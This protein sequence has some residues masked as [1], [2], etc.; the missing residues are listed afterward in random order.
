[1]FSAF[2]GTFFYAI[3]G[4]DRLMLKTPAFLSYCLA[5]FSMV[6]YA[7]TVTLILLSFGPEGSSICLGDSCLRMLPESEMGLI[8]VIYGLVAMV[9]MIGAIMFVRIAWRLQQKNGTA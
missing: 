5:I 4:Y 1:M 9:S 3:T 6:V 8:R 7:V 2:G